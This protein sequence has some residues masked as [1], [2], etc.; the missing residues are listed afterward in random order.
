MLQLISL[1]S[2]CMTRKQKGVPCE[3]TGHW[4]TEALLS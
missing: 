4:Q 1:G 2:Y 3:I